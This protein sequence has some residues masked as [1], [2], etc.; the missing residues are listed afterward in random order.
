MRYRSLSAFAKDKQVALPRMKYRVADV[1][2][3]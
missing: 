1:T 3:F 2:E